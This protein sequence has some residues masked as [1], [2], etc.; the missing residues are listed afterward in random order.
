ME[1]QPTIVTGWNID[2]FDIPYLYNRSVQVLG[3]SDVLIHYH[4]SDK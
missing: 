2:F 3:Y 1:I 4:L